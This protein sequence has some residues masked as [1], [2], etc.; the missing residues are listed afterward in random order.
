MRFIT[1]SRSSPALL[2][3]GLFPRK[4]PFEAESRIDLPGDG[5]APAPPPGP[6]RR[7]ASR[8]PSVSPAAS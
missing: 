8:A 4:V 3:G 5:A 7:A 1:A 6:S 2:K